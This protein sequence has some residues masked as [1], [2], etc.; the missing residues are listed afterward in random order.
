MRCNVKAILETTFDQGVLAVY[1]K[2]AIACS[3]ADVGLF[4]SLGEVLS[5]LYYRQED[6]VAVADQR[7]AATPSAEITG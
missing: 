7:S 5:G 3:D 6:L 2:E 1:R 4:K